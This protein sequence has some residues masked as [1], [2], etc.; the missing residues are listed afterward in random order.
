MIPLSIVSRLKNATTGVTFD[1]TRV[2]TRTPRIYGPAIL[3]LLVLLTSARQTR[4]GH[5]AGITI[6]HD[7]ANPFFYFGTSNP[8]G[9]S[10]D[11]VAA[12]G[13][14]P[15]FLNRVTGGDTGGAD[16][17]FGVTPTNQSVMLVSL[18]IHV[19]DTAG[20]S[21]SLAALN[22][23]ALGDIVA[24]LTANGG[25]NSFASVIAYQFT[26][27]P[28]QYANAV[29][30]LS[31]GET[32]YGGQP[33]DILLVATDTG[34]NGIWGVSFNG[35]IGQLDGITAINVTDIGAIT[36]E[37]DAPT[38]LLVLLAPTLL[39]RRRGSRTLQQPILWN[40]K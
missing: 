26:A 10:S 37:P 8:G 5:S 16:G 11:G 38:S 35:E 12:V 3:G 22:D 28:Q 13:N 20:T 21:H 27:V 6:A 30:L 24:D 29:S 2:T 9:G 7:P 25:Q 36:P 1:L 34:F 31:S 4:A 17:E 32:T 23:P 33:F 39:L 40:R 19:T 15:G 14:N 18:A